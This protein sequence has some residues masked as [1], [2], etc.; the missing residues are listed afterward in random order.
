MTTP[1]GPELNDELA[2]VIDLAERR[3]QDLE[4]AHARGEAYAF[5]RVV[6]DP[7]MIGFIDDTVCV[8]TDPPLKGIALTR[9]DAAALAR[10]LLEAVA[11]KPEV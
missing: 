9:E 10:D 2:T 8:I 5:A 1:R 7:D 11:R 3:H 4:Q 6:Y